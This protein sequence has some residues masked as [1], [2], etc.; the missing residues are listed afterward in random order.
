MILQLT[1]DKSD[2]LPV[3]FK[4]I[5][6]TKVTYS[7]AQ[8]VSSFMTSKFSHFLCGFKKNHNSQYSLLNLIEI[9]RKHVDE[10]DRI[11]VILMEFSKAF[12]TI[13][14]SLLLNK[15]EASGYSAIF[16]KSM[17]CCLCS[18]LQRT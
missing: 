1:E 12:D 2:C 4:R 10:R 9:W 5:G 11:D 7:Y 6:D 13:N 14:G 16:L 15:L 3:F 17:W 8:N 18:R